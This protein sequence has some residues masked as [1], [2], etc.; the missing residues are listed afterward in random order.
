MTSFNPKSF[1]EPYKSDL[2]Q[3]HLQKSMLWGTAVQNNPLNG[4]TNALKQE[5]APIPQLKADSFED[6]KKKNKKAKVAAFSLGSTLII[7]AL[8]I[9][10]GTKAGRKTAGKISSAISSGISKYLKKLYENNR[11]EKLDNFIRKFYRT[12]DTVGKYSNSVENVVNGKDVL[13]TAFAD[14]MTLRRVN[15]ENMGP[16]KKAAVDLYKKTIGRFFGAYENYK[17]ATSGLYHTKGVIKVDQRYAKAGKARAGF[18]EE[19]LNRLKEIKK[20]SRAEET[21]LYKGK[22]VKIKDA[23]ADLEKG[24]KTG[25]KEFDA[26]FGR[27][28]A[29][30]RLGKLYNNFLYGIQ[31]G[32]KQYETLESATTKEFARK[33]KGR[34]IKELLTEPVARGLVEGRK[35]E[36]AANLS[37]A[38]QG[39]SSAIEETI[40]KDRDLISELA[41]KLGTDDLDSLYRFEETI[42]TFDKYKNQ[43]FDGSAASNKAKDAIIDKL[44]E[45][46]A[47][48]HAY[49]KKSGNKAAKEALDSVEA[50][51]KSVSNAAGNDTD[52][53]MNALRQILDPDTYEKSIL[54]KYKKSRKLF[55]KAFN[56]EANDMPDKFRDIVCGSAPTDFMTV[57]TSAGLLGLYTA[58]AENNDERVSIG[59]TTG[60]PILATVGMNLYGAVNAISG[61]TSMILSLAVGAVTKSICDVINK[62]YRKLRG[63]DENEKPSVKTIDDYIEPHKNKFENVFNLKD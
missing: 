30:E 57:I 1:S 20:S 7:G 39:V 37:K 23:I 51:K 38:K 47:S 34:K 40:K 50:V 10:G 42:K 19:V 12:K 43:V 53:L 45:L 11:S 8:S 3:K 9:L 48:L 13:T 22:T 55:E 44:D 2:L 4:Q 26:N 60:L 62:G 31:D 59:L 35:S 54:P 41:K 58:Q 32:K 17:A 27:G 29:E 25:Q 5:I 33:V 24:I 6:S 21:I 15:T 28:V 56:M 52:E 61:K 63:L 18:S 14:K 49:S 46:S 36:Y 16:V